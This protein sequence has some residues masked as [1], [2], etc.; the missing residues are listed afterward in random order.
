MKKYFLYNIGIGDR[1][2]LNYLIS[3]HT[4]SITGIDFERSFGIATQ[5]LSIPELIPFRLTPQ[6]IGVLAPHGVKGIN[7]IV[8]TISLYLFEKMSETCI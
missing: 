1:H 8:K 3:L 5:L 7:K 6:L 4:G 2:M